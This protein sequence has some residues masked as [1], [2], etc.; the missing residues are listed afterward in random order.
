MSRAPSIPAAA[1]LLCENCGYALAGLP[2][3]TPCSEC[4]T[5]AGASWPATR[6]GSR[7][8]RTRRQP[9]RW[10]HSAL[11]IIREPRAV[12]RRVRVDPRSSAQFFFCNLMIAATMAD[13]G[14]GVAARR[15]SLDSAIAL[16]VGVFGGL[17][18]L[19][20][21][22]TL[23][24]RYF[25]RASSRRWRITPAVAWSVCHHASVGWLVGALAMALVLATDP[26]G[27]LLGADWFNTWLSSTFNGRVAN[28]L[29]IPLR[30]TQII[31]PIVLGVLA[32]ETFVYFGT[33]QCRYANAPASA[34]QQGPA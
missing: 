8:Q 3:A 7:F 33:R 11:E 17:L 5:P 10:L 4:G 16:W 12:F 31:A 30:M 32:F 19:T 23:G 13:I 22:E 24:L 27:R 15:F 18:L 1:D 28:D 26:A 29:Y 2:A 21:I 9:G 34:A 6:P 25:A 20:Y 14:F